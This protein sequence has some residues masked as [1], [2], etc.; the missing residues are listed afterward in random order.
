MPS[1]AFRIVKNFD[2]AL[3]YKFHVE[4]EGV[5]E[6]QFTE[7]EGLKLEREVIEYKE[8][9]SNLYIH[10]FPGRIKQEN[11]RLRRGVT[12]SHN[13][14]DWFVQGALLGT[15]DRKNISIIVGD[16]S[17]KIV[18]RWDLL[19]AW[20]VRYEGPELK[21]DSIQ[22]ALELVEL[23]HHGLVLQKEDTENPMGQGVPPEEPETTP[24]P[25]EEERESVYD[26]EQEE[27]PPEEP[28]KTTPDSTV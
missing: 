7:C 1:G 23:A 11:I 4:I 14:W 13:L 8:G 26:L 15:V 12:Y 21:A 27:T 19:N 3:S 17:N 18:Q 10:K 6:G 16:A 25:P 2:P 28:P 22:A 24:P 9:G 20:P 5:I